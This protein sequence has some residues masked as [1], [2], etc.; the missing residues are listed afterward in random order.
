MGN[1]SCQSAT[2]VLCAVVLLLLALCSPALAV[3]SK[4]ERPYDPFFY[5][6]GGGAPVQA[7][8]DVTGDLTTAIVRGWVYGYPS[9]TMDG[10]VWFDSY[11][12]SGQYLG[13]SSAQTDSTGFF[14]AGDVPGTI[15]GGVGA[16]SYNDV[17]A[18]LQ[19]DGLTFI[20]P[21]QD[22]DFW[23]GAVHWIIDS[24]GPLESR[25]SDPVFRLFGQAPGGMENGLF[26]YQQASTWD[27][28]GTF[29]WGDVWSLPGVVD[30]AEVWY[31]P[32]E[33]SIV[34][35][36]DKSAEV[37]AGSR[38]GLIWSGETTAYRAWI[39]SPQWASGKPGAKVTLT[40][41]NWDASG[42]VFGFVGHA[43]APRGAT[44]A[45][46]SLH[47]AVPYPGS[48]ALELAIP[49]RASAGYAYSIDATTT[50]LRART[51]PILMRNEYQVC[52]LRASSSSITRGHTVKLS[53]VVPVAGHWGKH[54]GTRK[55]V[56]I[57]ATRTAK[58]A[59]PTVWDATAEGWVRVAHVRTDG[60]GAYVTAHA[61]KPKR[62]TW[63]VC[64]YP[65]D[66]EYFAAFTAVQK[67]K[68]HK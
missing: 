46:G 43:N 2:V 64:R 39:S 17:F 16:V 56:D 52:T 65:G 37:T 9:G 35:P 42:T 67:V 29:S 34:A 23:P 12:T 22:F 53:G 15:G 58:T 41:E 4:V 51:D 28:S 21:T 30:Y 50:L 27:S 25:R 55:Y 47:Y 26:T 38:S 20:G 40:F 44:A 48:G 36:Y 45:W 31:A 1:R 62:T 66:A 54:K 5:G 59:P 10:E 11:D 68:V 6:T 3:T 7:A 19:T 57:Y 24:G 14:V 13:G 61:L 63:Y 32:N 33:M 8:A 49:A 60:Y 18:Y